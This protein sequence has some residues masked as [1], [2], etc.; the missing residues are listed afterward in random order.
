MFDKFLLFLYLKNKYLIKNL[1][2]KK[3]NNKYN[4]TYNIYR[5][6]DIQSI[7][8]KQSLPSYKYNFY[9][10]I[11]YKN[12]NYKNINYKNINYK[13]INYKNY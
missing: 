4:F 11:N 10:N 13:N 5:N 1:F 12:I 8:H 9:K 2:F 6:L 7:L 3:N